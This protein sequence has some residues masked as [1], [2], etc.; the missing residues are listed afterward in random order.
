MGSVWS[1]EAQLPGSMLALLRC[2]AYGVKEGLSL[3]LSQKHHRGL[4]GVSRNASKTIW[5]VFFYCC[6]INK[7]L[8]GLASI[9]VNTQG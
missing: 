8:I 9:S 2:L 1:R 6:F 5:A 7:V 4:R 3:M